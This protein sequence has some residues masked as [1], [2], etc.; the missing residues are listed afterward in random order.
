LAEEIGA[1]HKSA[2]AVLSAFDSWLLMRGMKTLALRLREQE[3]NAKEIVTFL[4]QHPFVSHVYYPGKGGMLSFKIKN[5]Q[6]VN[7]FLKHLNHITFAESLGGTES[8]ITYPATQTHADVPIEVR[9][10]VGVCNC[11]LRFSVGIEHIDDLKADL[12]QALT[13]GEDAPYE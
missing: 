7:T 8:F 10:A 9:T 11:L 6:A 1:I 2:G 4:K 12:C 3:K 13:F 5:E